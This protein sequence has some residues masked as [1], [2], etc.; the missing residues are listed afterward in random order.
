MLS[1]G[2]KWLI[3]R[4][5]PG[6]G[7]QIAIFWVSACSVV[8]RA[9]LEPSRSIS[10]K[11]GLPPAPP[12]LCERPD[13]LANGL[14]A[15]VAG[16]ESL[17][18]APSLERGLPTRRRM[19]SRGPKWLIV[20]GSSGR[21]LQIAIF[22]VSACSVVRRAFLEPSRSVSCK[23]GLPPAPPGLCE[24]PDSL[25]NGLPAHVAGSES[26]G[27]APCLERG[28]PTRR[29]MLSDGPKWLIMRGSS[30]RGLQIAIFWVS[31]C[32]VVRRA[33][34]EPSRSVSCRSGLPLLSKAPSDAEHPE[35]LRCRLGAPLLTRDV[36][37]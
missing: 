2:P 36:A 30:G 13:S 31:A 6:R 12:G 11:S 21:G 35:S 24:R 5:S 15:H 1:G 16:S 37:V 23:S 32:S 26:L 28:L 20:R 25:A 8:R 27:Q 17:G 18:Q 22:W 34:L 3:V 19:L 10:C 9:F 4:G 33:F 29:R 7:L 14:P